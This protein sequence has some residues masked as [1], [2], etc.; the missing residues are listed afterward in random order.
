MIEILTYIVFKRVELF[1]ML[2]E[3]KL[4]L[5]KRIQSLIIRRYFRLHFEI[6]FKVIS[7]SFSNTVDFGNE[8]VHFLTLIII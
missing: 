6:L 1:T 7:W 5:K 8:S 4:E 2:C 3:I